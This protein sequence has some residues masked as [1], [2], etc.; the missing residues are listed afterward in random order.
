[1]YYKRGSEFKLPYPYLYDF[2]TNFS[3]NF[4]GNTTSTGPMATNG[5][6]DL[7]QLSSKSSFTPVSNTQPSSQTETSAMKP[8]KQHGM[9]SVKVQKSHQSSPSGKVKMSKQGKAQQQGRV[10]K[11]SSV[12]SSNGSNNASSIY[13]NTFDPNL[14]KF[15]NTSYSTT[16]M[17]YYN[18]THQ[19][20]LPTLKTEL[21]DDS[22]SSVNPG[23]VYDSKAIATSNSVTSDYS[24]MSSASSTSS[25]SSSSSETSYNYHLNPA[26]YYSN[27]ANYGSNGTNGQF[28]N[29]TSGQYYNGFSN[30]TAGS[31]DTGYSTANNW[32]TSDSSTPD[33]HTSYSYDQFGNATQNGLIIAAAKY[34][35]A[36]SA[37]YY[38]HQQQ[39]QQQQPQSYP[40]VDESYLHQSSSP[41]QANIHQA[42]SV[43]VGYYKSKKSY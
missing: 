22:A 2:E 3:S 7:S 1:M 15:S 29:G 4:N 33:S 18:S 17:D 10:T 23:L 8:S 27:Y 5:P 36:A 35:C 6:P 40:F 25:T 24:S 21:A 39:Q 32:P 38:S 37:A 16:G 13:A 43:S 12:A 30:Y 42:S 41:N 11:S 31:G 26:S 14:Y 9:N 19:M 28:Y 34:S 20:P